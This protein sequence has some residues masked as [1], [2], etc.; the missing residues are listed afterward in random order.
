MSYHFILSTQNKDTR[1]VYQSISQSI[2]QS[3]EIFSLA[4][5]ETITE[6][7][8]SWTSCETTVE[9]GETIYEIKKIWAVDGKQ[10]NRVMTGCPVAE[11]SGGRMLQQETRADQRYVCMHVFNYV[12]FGQADW[13]THSAVKADSLIESDRIGWVYYHTGCLMVLPGGRC[14]KTRSLSKSTVYNINNGRIL[15][16]ATTI[17]RNYIISV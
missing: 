1:Y 7:T 2:N 4:Q 15:H 16:N 14:D 8:K 17:K 3:I 5:I 12:R 13:Q 10:L 9:C 11:S 6:T